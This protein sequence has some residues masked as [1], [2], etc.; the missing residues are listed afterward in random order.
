[1]SRSSRC[2]LLHFLVAFVTEILYQYNVLFIGQ[3]ELDV[4]QFIKR[5]GN[6][7]NLSLN[8]LFRFLHYNAP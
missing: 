6:K 1:M 7:V 2:I 3:G 5:F 8:Q 4:F